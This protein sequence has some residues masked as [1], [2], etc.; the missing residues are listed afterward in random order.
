MSKKSFTLVEIMIVTGILVILIGLAIPGILRSHLVGQ[1][2]R[3]LANLKTIMNACNFYYI[4]NGNVY[5]DS[6]SVLSGV[7]PSYLPAELSDGN[8]QNYEFLYSLSSDGFTINANPTGMIKGR[9]FF[10]DE[11]GLIHAR[12][13]EPAD[14]NDEI[15]R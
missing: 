8:F 7:N 3:A 10:V 9:Y 13:G 1:E 6:L 4:N 15:V 12:G 2:T 14:E 5:P 11:K